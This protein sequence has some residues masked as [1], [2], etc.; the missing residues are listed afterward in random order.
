MSEQLWLDAANTVVRAGMIPLPVTE[1][2]I[3]LLQT[4]M[5]PVQASFLP[6]FDGPM[7]MGQL[8][9]KTGWEE[10]A[11]TLMLEGLMD[12]GIVTGTRSKGSGTL[13]YRLMGPFPGMFEFTMMRGE[14]GEKQKKLARLFD[15]MFDELAG[16]VRSNYDSIVPAFRAF[17]PVARVVP[18]RSEIDTSKGAVLPADEVNR[19]VAKFDTIAVTTCYCRHEKELLGEP[20]AVTSSKENCLMFGKI[21]QFA[22]EHRFARPISKDDAFRILRESEE[23]GLV[24]KAFHV[25]LDPDR[26][27]EAICNCCKCCCGGI[28]AMVRWGVPMVTS[29]GYLAERSGRECIGCGACA[30]ACPFLAITL[31]G[32]G[33][34]VDRERCMGCGVCVGRC[35][36]GALALVRAPEK[37]LPLDVRVLA[38]AAGG[39]AA[40]SQIPGN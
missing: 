35:P 10:P 40:S 38:P 29:S 25:N 9:T 8:K 33:A 12:N 19:I 16:M 6:H 36:G 14:T 18:M 5:T 30:A 1:T 2:M 34:E 37:G 11:L 39:S 28:D 15:R 23:E 13:V 7:N 21:A 20:C 27:E 22:M 26:E 24:H 32:S 17:P 31:N 3:Q 4:M